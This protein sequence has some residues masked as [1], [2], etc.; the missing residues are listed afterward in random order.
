MRKIAIVLEGQFG[1]TKLADYLKL[2][3]RIKSQLSRLVKEKADKEGAEIKVV[4]NL[5]EL[6]RYD[7]EL[8]TVIFLSRSEI[9]RA[10]E[11][12]KKDPGLQV[13]VI[14][15][16]I[17]DAEVILLDKAWLTPELWKNILNLQWMKRITSGLSARG[18]LF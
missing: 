4:D 3:E 5:N 18:F 13:I 7:P 15:G 12:K 9:L 14:S 6:P 8:K 10:R 17:E 16:A 2:A 11:L 1:R